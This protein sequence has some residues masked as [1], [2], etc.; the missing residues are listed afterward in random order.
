MMGEWSSAGNMLQLHAGAP[1]F[2]AMPQE[3]WPDIEVHNLLHSLPSVDK[4][5]VQ[6]RAMCR[7]EGKGKIRA[8]GGRGGG[9]GVR[10]IHACQAA[11]KPWFWHGINTYTCGVQRFTHV[12]A[13]LK[14]LDEQN[15]YLKVIR[16][17]FRNM[18]VT[19]GY[20]WQRSCKILLSLMG[21]GG[22]RL[23]S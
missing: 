8:W 3:A 12:F 19:M 23:C 9:V 17:L 1:W 20:R 18:H 5:G 7:G 13:S 22:R 21:I 4:D 15:G 16:L 10:Y 2:A 6:D 14:A 11:C